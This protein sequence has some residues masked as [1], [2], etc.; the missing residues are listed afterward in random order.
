MIA[1][2][3]EPSRGAQPCDWGRGSDGGVDTGS[4]L[5]AC[6][7]FQPG[8]SVP[9]SRASHRPGSGS[10]LLVR[11][12]LRGRSRSAQDGDG[13]WCVVAPWAQI[14]CGKTVLEYQACG[15]RLG[16]EVSKGVAAIQ[17]EAHDEETV[18]A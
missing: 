8:G 16:I 4:C 1:Q 11:T 2:P 18:V 14:P 6:E 13:E 17:T 10:G 3:L 12:R 9:S 5:V 15:G 7:R